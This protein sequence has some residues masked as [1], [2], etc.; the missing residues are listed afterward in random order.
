M[1]VVGCQYGLS[2]SAPGKIKNVKMLP[3]NPSHILQ[4]PCHICVCPTSVVGNLFLYSS[5][6]PGMLFLYHLWGPESVQMAEGH[7][8]QAKRPD[9]W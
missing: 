6:S 5:S 1:S 7:L 3:S 9:P 8:L 4:S 2:I